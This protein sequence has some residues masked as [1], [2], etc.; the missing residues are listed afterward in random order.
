MRWIT[1]WL[2][3]LKGAVVV[4]RTRQAWLSRTPDKFRLTLWNAGRRCCAEFSTLSGVVPK[5]P[6]Q[7]SEA[8]EGRLRQSS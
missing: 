5:L 6:N 3:V 4:A 7:W 2:G 1:A 8:L